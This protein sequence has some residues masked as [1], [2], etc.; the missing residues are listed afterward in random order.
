[1]ERPKLEDFYDQSDPRGISSSERDEYMTALKV[2]EGWKRKRYEDTYKYN[3]IMEV[4]MPITDN[5]PETPLEAFIAEMTEGMDNPQAR[6]AKQ[7]GILL[8]VQWQKERMYTEDDLKAAHWNGWAQREQL[9][10]LHF[11]NGLD[12]EEK[13]E[14]VFNE[15]LKNTK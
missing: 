5:T 11:P 6:V 15:W 3:P 9:D 1:M 4:P 7:R 2:Y 12:Y 10:N 8:G 13:E 14:Y